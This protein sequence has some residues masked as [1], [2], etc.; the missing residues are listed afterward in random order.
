MPGLQAN[1]LIVRLV[2]RLRP[3]GRLRFTLGPPKFQ[4]GSPN[5]HLKLMIIRLTSSEQTSNRLP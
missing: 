3:N 5:G 1:V 2:S 4:T